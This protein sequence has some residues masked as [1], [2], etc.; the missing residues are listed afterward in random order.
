MALYVT[1]SVACCVTLVDRVIHNQS[2]FASNVSIY[3]CYISEPLTVVDEYGT[4]GY[5]TD[6]NPSTDLPVVD[7]DVDKHNRES[8]NS[9]VDAFN[10]SGPGMSNYG[11]SINVKCTVSLCTSPCET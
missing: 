9:S 10:K 6:E 8:S 3:I 1:C 2:Y 7:K 4:I 11:G 5:V